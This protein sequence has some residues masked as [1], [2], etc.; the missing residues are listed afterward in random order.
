MSTLPDPTLRDTIAE[1]LVRAA[2]NSSEIDSFDAEADAVLGLP[3][4]QAIRAVLEQ[5]ALQEAFGVLAEA[6]DASPPSHEMYAMAA[7]ILAE[8]FHLQ[9]AVV[10]WVLQDAHKPAS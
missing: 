4:M 10:R 8:W 9:P 6:P 3:E 1:A 5:I 7:R 2:V